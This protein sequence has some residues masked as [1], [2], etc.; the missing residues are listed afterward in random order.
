M[1]DSELMRETVSIPANTNR[2][3]VAGRE[4]LACFTIYRYCSV[5]FG[6]LT[7]PRG[8]TDLVAVVEF[9]SLSSFQRHCH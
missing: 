9:S 4:L 7:F 3:I 2:T 6:Q 5:G 8:I 1:P